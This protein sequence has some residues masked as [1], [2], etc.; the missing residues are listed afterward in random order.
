MQELTCSWKF[1]HVA[2]LLTLVGKRSPAHE[3]GPWT[4]TVLC[5]TLKAAKTIKK[6][7]GVGTSIC[8]NLTRFNFLNNTTQSV[9]K[10][11][12]WKAWQDD[13]T[14]ASNLWYTVSAK[15]A[16]GQSQ[17]RT[18]YGLLS[19][20]YLLL[21]VVGFMHKLAIDDQVWEVNLILTSLGGSSSIMSPQPAVLTHESV[22]RFRQRHTHTHFP[23]LFPFYKSHKSLVK[24]A[25]S[26]LLYTLIISV[27]NR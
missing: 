13:P 11:T 22:N 21:V 15:I 20:V 10:W 12:S 19:S 24:S 14:S 8:S 6:T 3:A 4:L 23:P 27:M 16:R 5:H 9:H 7:M 2:H 26:S 1:R 18:V 25:I 17:R